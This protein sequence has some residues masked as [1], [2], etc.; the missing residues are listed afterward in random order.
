MGGGLNPNIATGI[1]ITQINTSKEEYALSVRTYKRA[2][3]A[4]AVRCSI[5]QN[6]F[7]DVNLS[8]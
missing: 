4:Y 2:S 3:L 7:V 1:I 6:I 5:A 8:S